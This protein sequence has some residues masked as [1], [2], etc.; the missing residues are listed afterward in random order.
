MPVM[1]VIWIWTLNIQYRYGYGIQL[2]GHAYLPQLYALLS[3]L[4]PATCAIRR[5]VE[6]FVGCLPP[7]VHVSESS[8]RRPG[9]CVPR[10]RA[11]GTHRPFAGA[12]SRQ[13]GAQ[14]PSA[15]AP[16]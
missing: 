9:V 7:V 13:P 2:C 3:H 16:A 10:W 11:T 8:L 1:A 6:A 12:L 15:C 4:L 5:N 14:C